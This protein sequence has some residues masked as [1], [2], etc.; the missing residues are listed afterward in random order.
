[1]ASSSATP[2]SL[3]AQQDSSRTSRPST[4]VSVPFSQTSSTVASHADDE[5][6]SVIADFRQE[7]YGPAIGEKG[8]DQYEV[9]FSPDDPEDP[10]N[11][12]RAK[13]W[14]ITLLAGMLVLNA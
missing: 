3:S 11:W 12:S 7:A 9:S 4:A 2:P 6:D 1:M 10:H 14:Y 13:R 5:A 8:Y